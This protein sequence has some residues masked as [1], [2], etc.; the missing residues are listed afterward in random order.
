MT[1]PP[2]TTIPD[3]ATPDLA[4]I[5]P[6]HNEADNL[7]PLVAE[8]H[9]ALQTTGLSYHIVIVDDRSTDDTARILAQLAAEDPTVKP[10]RITATGHGQRGLGPSAACA[11]G[12]R[13]THAPIVCS[14]DADLQNPPAALPDMIQRL[15]DEQLDLV[16]GDRSANRRD[17]LKRRVSSKVGRAFRG[18]IL[19]DDTPDS[20]CAL[21]VLSRRAA[22]AVPLQYKGMHRFIAPWLKM[23][24]YAVA[25][26]PTDHRP[27]AAG[28]AKFGIWNRAI[29]GLIDL[30]AVRWMALRLRPTDAQPIA[31][32]PASTP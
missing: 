7:R 1:T 23:H 11:V 14:L 30:F 20:A 4:I 6:A 26:H 32:D 15:K 17:N 13:S 27:R 25:N 10:V 21:R 12:F 18:F 5:A 16:Q 24:G 3:D 19:N 22:H 2:D 31:P 8:I 29:P 28:T 9:Q